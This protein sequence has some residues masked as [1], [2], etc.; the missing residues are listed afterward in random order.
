MDG[1]KVAGDWIRRYAERPEAGSVVVCLPHA[2]GSATFYL[3]VARAAAPWADVLAV[4]Y[5]GRQERRHE[6]CVETVAELAD[7]IAEELEPWTARPVILFGHSMGATVAYEVARRLEARGL[8]PAGLFASA[9]PAPSIVRDR[10]LHRLPDADLLE[11]MRRLGGTAGA[12]LREEELMRAA[13]RAIRSDYRAIETYRH[14]EGPVLSCPVVALVGEDDPRASVEDA[15]AWRAHTTGAFRLHTFSG[16]HFYLTEHAQR[17]VALIE[18]HARETA[19][20]PS[21][22]R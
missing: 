13:L 18:A 17:V 10:G 19:A 5:P 15:A 3:P 16:G 2:G 1:N 8:P 21:S 22:A 9:R 4:Q 7:L 20:S 14:P 12:V 6:P 11:E